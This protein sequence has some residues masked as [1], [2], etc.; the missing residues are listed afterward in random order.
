MSVRK[1]EIE[2]VPVWAQGAVMYQIFVDRFF[3]GDTGNDVRDGEYRYLDVWTKHKEW[4]ELPEP[5][6]VANFYGGD[7][8]GVMQKLDYLEDMGVEVIYLNP[9]FTSPSNHKYDIEDYYRVDPHFGSNELAAQLFGEIHKRGMRVIL[10]GVFNHCSDRNPWM[11]IQE[12]FRYNRNG[13]YECWWD[14]AT[15]PK[16]NYEGSER[17]IDEVM[18]IAKYWLREPYCIDGWRLDVAAD[19][20]H[21][22]EFNHRFW[23]RFRKEVRSVNPEALIIAEHYGNPSEWLKGNEWDTVMNYDYFMEPVSAFLTGMDKHSDSFDESA[24]GDGVR[25]KEAIEAVNSVMSREARLAAMS[26][27]DNHDHSRFLTRTNRVAGRLA[28]L[29][30]EAAEDGTNICF[31]RQAQLLQFTLPG[32]PAIYYGDEAGLRGFTDPDSRRTY[33]WGKE[34]RE[35]IEF[36]RG[37]S[38]L[39]RELET[40]R[41][42]KIEWLMAEQNLIAF[43]RTKQAAGCDDIT[44]QFT[45]VVVNTEYSERDIEI[46]VKLPDGTVFEGKLYTDCWNFGFTGDKVEVLDGRLKIKIKPHGGYILHTNL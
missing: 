20:G 1:T 26:E 38:G 39:H 29:G 8:A 45:V 42:G 5:F 36:C 31:L 35:C 4:N 18:E 44:S 10:D 12:Y 27:L 9:I 3:N 33:P 6:D 22:E 37:V 41:N 19:V 11:Q 7:L 43:A 24:V 28:T 21:S 40:L 46:P 25:F 32:A 34:D 16:L 23:Q 14:N 13:E 30:A 15:L 2:D 17:L